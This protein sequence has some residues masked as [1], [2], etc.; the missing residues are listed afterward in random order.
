MP[1]GRRF[2]DT[3]NLKA[4]H[5]IHIVRI[6]VEIALLYIFYAGLIPEVMTFEGR[7]F[8]ILAGITAPLM[9]YLFFG[10]KTISKKVMITWNIIGILLLVNIVA[11]AILSAPFSFQ[12]LAFDQPNTGLFFFPFTWLPCYIVPVVF[13]SHF[14]SLRLLLKK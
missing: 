6:P 1:S 2:I 5:W 11:H 12:Q 4:L 9:V 8:D 14:A 3:L 10:R 7:N 13:F